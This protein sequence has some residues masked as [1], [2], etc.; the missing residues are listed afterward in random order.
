M[1]CA[2]TLVASGSFDYTVRTWFLESGIPAAV[3]QG[4]QNIVSEV[5]FCPRSARVLLSASWDQTLRVWDAF[6]D[7]ATSPPTVLKLYA[8]EGE[9]DGGGGGAGI[10]GTTGVT[11][12][13]AGTPSVAVAETLEEQRVLAAAA[14]TAARAAQDRAA[15]AATAGIQQIEP[16][17]PVGAVMCTAW[18]VDGT[19]FACGTTTC[20][21]HVFSV[22]E[23]VLTSDKE[24]AVD[25]T[26]IN[27]VPMTGGHLHDVTS[28]AFS[29]SGELLLTSSRDGQA[30]I[31]ERGYR[32]ETVVGKKGK[33]LDKTKQPGVGCWKVRA[34]LTT[35]ADVEA[36]R[37]Q[38]RARRGPVVY[39]VEQA[40]WSSDDQY[41]LTAMSDFTVRVWSVAGG[42]LV[43]TMRL[44][45][46][47]VHVL[48]CHPH[49]SRIAMSA[50]HDGVVAV[51]DVVSGRCVRTYDGGEFDTLVLDG[52]WSPC[53]T[54]I[55][56]SDEKGQWCLFGTGCGVH[57][58]R[59]KHEQFFESEF[60][61]ETE[62]AR[63]AETGALSLA[64][65]PDVPFHEQFL[66]ARNRLVDSLGNPYG[67]PYQSAFQQKRL[68]G[69]VPSSGTRV[70]PP[71]CVG[72]KEAEEATFAAAAVAVAAAAAT[73][74]ATAVRYRDDDEYVQID[75]NSD[76]DGDEEVVIVSGDDQSEEDESDDDADDA[77]DSDFAQKRRAR[78][79][80]DSRSGSDD[81]AA[82]PSMGRA[83]RASRREL[84]RDDRVARRQVRRRANPRTERPRRQTRRLIGDDSG[85]STDDDDD[86]PVDRRTT[87]R[88]RSRP[89]R[90][91]N[92]VSGDEDDEDDDEEEH[93]A[94]QR[95]V[96]F[97]MKRRRDDGDDD[98]ATGAGGSRD[99]RSRGNETTHTAARPYTSY[100]WLLGDTNTRGASY[101]PQLGDELV[102]VPHGHHLFLENCANKVAAR[103]WLGVT[104]HVWRQH[105]P[106]RVVGLRYRISGDT[107][108]AE[109]VAVVTLRLADT[110][111]DVGSSQRH[112]GDAGGSM[113]DAGSSRHQSIPKSTPIEFEVELPKLDD[114][115]FLVP[116]HRWRAA[117]KKKWKENNHCAVSWDV[118]DA[119]GESNNVW[120]SCVV[121]SCGA[122]GASGGAGGPSSA[123]QWQTS[124]WNKLQIKYHNQSDVEEH[125]FWELHDEHVSRDLE[126]QTQASDAEAPR[127]AKQVSRKLSDR[128]RSA[129]R[130]TSDYDVFSSEIGNHV[131]FPQRDGSDVNY[132]S[133]VP[134]PVSL[135]LL[136][137]RLKNGYYRHVSGFCHDVETIA[138]NCI[139]FNGEDSE[140]TAMARKLQQELTNGVDTAFDEIA[141]LPVR[142]VAAGELIPS[143]EIAASPA[144]R[145]R[146]R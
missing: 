53:G 67:E 69:V 66:A 74:A 38:A 112:E 22:P 80:S 26:E 100:A 94:P 16:D 113:R 106:V 33:P 124:P 75:V 99:V 46:N 50:G 125:S 138:T 63:D 111:D 34:V 37:R 117:F 64:A 65:N 131:S 109:T 140:Y 27:L 39:A 58:S 92:V 85:T 114:A 2:N 10:A 55:V 60:V 104:A 49:D 136:Y 96:R 18:S 98:D 13:P 5:R 45:T 116:A 93:R 129:I 71:K 146:R 36:L 72:A 139:L 54:S 32:H 9:L 68:I 103:P 142:G 134:V 133:L 51:W 135:D 130:N 84:A 47:K 43:H 108:G 90:L 62:I 121:L 56:V 126:S 12:A 119:D 122:P 132:V 115:D 78:R 105:E 40:V 61:L 107:V 59:A 123:G 128:V 35:P 81:D 145:G 29:N 17:P 52:S 110:G 79:G 11:A 89:E 44:H 3:L 6:A 15:E 88:N 41:V 83:E 21:T 48:Q 87:G 4:H 30:K 31:W 86:D 76:D 127:L 82:G 97:T 141:D 25:P 1:N 14:A 118:L 101:T 120:Y 57:V 91:G 42:T 73:A 137:R 77:S 28:C 8:V 20:K 144:G 24:G 23:S 95:V 19:L 7:S 70:E 143:A 102:Y